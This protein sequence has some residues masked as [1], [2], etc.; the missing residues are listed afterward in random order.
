MISLLAKKIALATIGWA[1]VTAASAVAADIA[2]FSPI[3]F[4]EDGRVFAFEEY[5]VQDGSGF[6][7]SNIFA[8]DVE[9]DTFIEGTPI[10]VRIDDEAA[11]IGKARSEAAE[12]AKAILGA[13]KMDDHPGELVAFN[14]VSAGPSSSH[15]LRYYSFPTDPPVG[16]P[17]AIKLQEIQGELPAAC[18]DLVPRVKSFRL[19]LTSRDGKPAN[20]TLYQDKA[21]PE[22]RGC[23]TGYRLGGI[24]T[25][26]PPAGGDTLHIA[27]V[28]VLSF[29]FEG[30]DGRWIA[31]P[32]RP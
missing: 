21:I 15:M 17:Y 9:Q 32:V 22:S 28:T 11:G 14:P 6:P 1:A 24:M 27:L 30:R 7:Y 16:S 26:Q 31:V 29:G 8:I 23:V 3:G 2:T 18:K 13:Y 12:K 10:R 19:V 25:Y 4:S 5:G 20:D